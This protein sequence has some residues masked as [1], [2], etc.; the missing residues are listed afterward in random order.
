MTPPP[1]V[2]PVSPFRGILPYRYVDREWFFGREPVVERLLAK[3]LLYRLTILFGDSGAGKSSV[4]SA[5]LTAALMKEDLRAERLRVRPLADAPFMLERI[6]T[7]PAGNRDFLPS[8]FELPEGGDPGATS[9]AISLEQFREKAGAE[10]EQTPVL[11]LDQFEEL[12]TLFKA[13]ESELQR[14]VMDAIFDVLRDTGSRTRVVIGIREDYF[15]KLEILAKR[16]PSVM[17]FRVQLLPLDAAGAKHAALGAFE[18]DAGWPSHFTEGLAEEMVAELSGDTGLISNTQL[19]ILCSRVWDKYASVAPEI[20]VEEYRQLGGMEGILGQFFN[21][22]TEKLGPTRPLAI[23]ALGLL[24]TAEGTRDVVSDA[25]LYELLIEEGPRPVVEQVLDILDKQRLIN[26]REQNGVRYNEVASEYLIVPLQK[27]VEEQRA[28]DALKQAEQLLADRRSEYERQLE[29]ERR[30]KQGLV[31]LMVLI[32]ALATAGYK[33]YSAKVQSAFVAQSQLVRVRQNL[34]AKTQEL[35][36]VKGKT[37]DQLRAI[38][39]RDAVIRNQATQIQLLRLGAQGGTPVITPEPVRPSPPPPPLTAEET[40]TVV[41]TGATASREKRSPTVLKSIDILIGLVVI[42]LMISLAVTALTQ[43][44]NSMINL[45]GRQLR[46]GLARLIRQISPDTTEEDAR[47]IAFEVLM[48]PLI[49]GSGLNMVSPMG[50]VIHREELTGILIG[51]GTADSANAKAV[52]VRKLL[53]ENGIAD[54][55][56]TANHVRRMSLELEKGNPGLSG[57]VRQNVALM[58]EADS[59]LVAKINA[60][61]DPTMDRVTERFTSITRAITFGCALLVAGLVQLDSPW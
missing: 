36:A 45:R 7:T 6:A 47:S 26:R 10:Y 49:R 1:T 27:S 35:E 29:R 15:G 48:H 56:A 9:I 55:A 59:D 16:Y 17:D 58:Q 33:V 60:W 24:V 42:L 19:Q 31:S 40:T 37:A 4:L 20:G 21:A 51:L 2:R 43:F 61:F 18:R 32:V 30:K 41:H 54:P 11:I 28:E 34:Q 14:K 13:P 57:S 44:V 39:I 8:I 25:K 3:V 12:F 38:E 23:K 22:A 50:A 46:L 5:G 53:N 52:A